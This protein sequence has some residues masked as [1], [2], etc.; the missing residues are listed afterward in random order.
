MHHLPLPSTMN[1][2]PPLTPEDAHARKP[3]SGV[4][5]KTAEETGDVNGLMAHAN[6]NLE[7]LDHRS[8]SQGGLFALLPP[9]GKNGEESGKGIFSQW[10]LYTQ[11]LVGTVAELEREIALM[12]ELLGS[13]HRSPKVHGHSTAGQKG[14]TRP[15]FP[16]D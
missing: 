14:A 16:Q 4:V 9:G 2:L 3:A 7:L 5:W 10:L 15:V 12:R 8:S 13:E 11:S 6:E 1:T